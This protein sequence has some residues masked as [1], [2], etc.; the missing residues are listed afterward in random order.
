MDFEIFL[1]QN[2]VVG[3]CYM[4]VPLCTLLVCWG[5]EKKLTMKQIRRIIWI[6][7]VVIWLILRIIMIERGIDSNSASLLW[8]ILAQWM[9]KK[10][11]L[12]KD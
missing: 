4:I 2:L 3:F 7:Y 5:Y 11:C 10:K 12:K 1:L 8:P 9:L 6:N